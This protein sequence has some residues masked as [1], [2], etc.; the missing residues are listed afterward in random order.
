ML[1][2]DLFWQA[3]LHEHMPARGK[4]DQPVPRRGGGR[5]T[6]QFVTSGE[7]GE[8]IGHDAGIVAA[9]R[10]Q[11]VVALDAHVD[12]VAELA[13]RGV[14]RAHVGRPGLRLLQHVPAGVGGKPRHVA[15]DE[16]A[17][18]AAGQTVEIGQPV[19]DERHQVRRA[20]RIGLLQY[21]QRAVHLRLV[22]P[23]QRP[24]ERGGQENGVHRWHLKL[25]AG[26]VILRRHREECGNIKLDVRR[27]DGSTDPLRGEG[28]RPDRLECAERH[29]QRAR[30]F[31]G[32]APVHGRRFMG[33]RFTGWL[34][35]GHRR[36]HRLLS[37][38]RSQAGDTN[39]GTGPGR[40]EL[41][42]YRHFRSTG[43]STPARSAPCSCFWFGRDAVR[44]HVTNAGKSLWPGSQS[45]TMVHS[46]GGN[47][48]EVCHGPSYSRDKE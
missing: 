27:D 26:A 25:H 37:P 21:R 22:G 47:F 30:P 44:D 39:R 4:A 20:P 11:H 31:E 48:G 46:R 19:G 40:H 36:I 6:A 24:F 38:S 41:R 8:H 13:D 28:K 18:P 14:G 7:P 29:R 2:G 23:G 33:R 42:G 5:T 34:V 3:H 1:P 32:R 15:G 45:G 10:E 12:V 43:T 35:H 16:T 9:Q 17:V